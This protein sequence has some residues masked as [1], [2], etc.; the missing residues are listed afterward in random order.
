MENRT[1]ANMAEVTMAMSNE[2]AHYWFGKIANGNRS[3]ALKAL[4]ILWEIEIMKV[5]D[6]TYLLVTRLCR[7]THIRRLCLQYFPATNEA[8]PRLH[9][10]P[11]RALEQLILLGN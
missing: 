8:E 11:G 7:G 4:G 10:L 9:R 2:E 3:N 5:A 6:L 1:I